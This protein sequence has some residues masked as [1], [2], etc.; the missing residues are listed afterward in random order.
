[1]F[2][3][4]SCEKACNFYY[5]KKLQKAALKPQ[6][7]TAAIRFLNRNLC[8]LWRLSQLMF[9]VQFFGKDVNYN[10]VLNACKTQKAHHP[11]LGS[12]RLKVG[13]AKLPDRLFRPHFGI[14]FSCSKPSANMPLRLIHLKHMPALLMQRRRQQFDAFTNILMYGGL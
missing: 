3:H 6:K 8:V 14:F 10:T 9:I 11:M 13:R 5:Q 7:A 12:V 4:L 2:K 1:M